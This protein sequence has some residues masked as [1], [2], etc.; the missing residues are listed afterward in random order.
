VRLKNSVWGELRALAHL[1][2][3][4]QIKL[5][6]NSQISTCLYLLHIGIKR[7]G[8]YAQTGDRKPA[9]LLLK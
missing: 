7:M 9:Y 6:S 4:M 3:V 2:L 8:Y 5:A 1:E